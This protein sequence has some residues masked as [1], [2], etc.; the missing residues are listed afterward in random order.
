MGYQAKKLGNNFK[1][2][3]CIQKGYCKHQIQLLLLH[4]FTPGL[5]V[6]LQSMCNILLVL[7]TN[8]D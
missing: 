1:S 8:T 6:I 2:I 4:L 7:V 5:Y 3:D